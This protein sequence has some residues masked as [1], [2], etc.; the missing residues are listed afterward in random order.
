MRFDQCSGG[1]AIL[2][3]EAWETRAAS[4]GASEGQAWQGHGRPAGRRAA[5]CARARRRRFRANGGRRNRYQM[6]SDPVQRRGAERG[7]GAGG[8]EAQAGGAQ[9]S[10]KG[11]LV[12]QGP[13]GRVVLGTQPTGVTHRFTVPSSQTFPNAD[14]ALYRNPSAPQVTPAL[15]W[16]ITFQERERSNCTTAPNLNLI[17]EIPSCA[18]RILATGTRF[19]PGPHTGGRAPPERNINQRVAFTALLF[20]C[21]EERISTIKDFLRPRLGAHRAQCTDN[22]QR[23]AGESHSSGPRRRPFSV[24]SLFVERGDPQQEDDGIE[25]E[26][27]AEPP[28]DSGAGRVPLNSF[29]TP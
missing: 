2:Q 27:S 5:V 8:P 4:G 15:M 22:Q 24:Y 23:V 14:G 13:A 26:P 28:C 11:G 12:T 9:L 17:I 3:S 10:A 6:R 19:G 16:N 1:K 7:R 29:L 20:L 25:N 21:G 18:P